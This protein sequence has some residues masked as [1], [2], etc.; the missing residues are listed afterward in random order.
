MNM[1]ILVQKPTEIQTEQ[2]Q[3]QGIQRIWQC[4]N[5]YNDLI[6][7]WWCIINRIFLQLTAWLPPWFMFYDQETPIHCRREV[8]GGCDSCGVWCV[9]AVAQNFNNYNLICVVAQASVIQW[10]MY[11]AQSGQIRNLC[12][13]LEEQLKNTQLIKKV[14]TNRPS[15]EM[16]ITWFGQ[17]DA[18][19]SPNLPL[20]SS[21]FGAGSAPSLD[22]TL[23]SQPEYPSI[24]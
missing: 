13:K 23:S 3:P 4:S 5:A 8:P 12:L 6:R 10:A 18:R 22:T 21:A 19:H 9:C 2:G 24:L 11:R 17:N 1:S 7:S 20:P 16:H 14:S 15:Q